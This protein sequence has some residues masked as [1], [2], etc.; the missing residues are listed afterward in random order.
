[1]ENEWESLIESPKEE[2]VEYSINPICQDLL[3]SDK[4]ASEKVTEMVNIYLL[5][6]PD[7]I[8]PNDK[9][10]MQH[11]S[12]LALYRPI[13]YWFCTQCGGYVELWTLMLA[14]AKEWFPNKSN[15][16]LGHAFCVRFEI[17]D[18]TWWNGRIEFQ[19]V[20]RDYIKWHYDRDM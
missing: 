16:K 9:D 5:S 8:L 19:P 4:N 6:Y 7:F 17:E 10:F 12:Y 1:M 3:K 2:L 20:L 15:T 13:K 11:P 18:C 14:A